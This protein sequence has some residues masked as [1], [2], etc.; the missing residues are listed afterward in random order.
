MFC[1]LPPNPIISTLGDEDGCIAKPQTSKS[2]GFNACLLCEPR[3]Y[4]KPHE[5]ITHYVLNHQLP[6]CQV[7][8]MVFNTENA[9]MTHEN[10]KHWPFRCLN[11]RLHYLRTDQLDQHIRSVHKRMRCELCTT[12]YSIAPNDE[13]TFASHLLVKHECRTSNEVFVPSIVK[14]IMPTDDDGLMPIRKYHC[15]L[16]DQTQSASRML[17]HFLS[18]HH[19]HLNRL[20]QMLQQ[21]QETNR[22]LLSRFGVETKKAETRP[23]RPFYALTFDDIAD[24]FEIC[25]R[26]GGISH[27]ATKDF[28]TDRVQYVA[29]SDDELEDYDVV[30][31]ADEVGNAEAAVVCKADASPKT[32]RPYRCP[33]CET[34]TLFNRSTLGR[35]MSGVHGFRLHNMEY[36]CQ[37]CR[38]K[39]VQLQS[40]RRHKLR[41][42]VVDDKSLCCPLCAQSIGSKKE[43]RYDIS[44]L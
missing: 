1:V 7:C 6:F 44:V 36:R 42:H 23:I 16:C 37:R 11:C 35:H 3:E 29:S 5:H 31:A 10:K 14:P 4:L 27:I 2:A 39:F 28:D 8:S 43:L 24:N 22:H 30:P 33:Y 19:V 26:D 12:T 38:Q 25:E 15:N 32:G 20:L 21:F 17:G 18:F 41:Q 13:A 40:L 34:S 9:R